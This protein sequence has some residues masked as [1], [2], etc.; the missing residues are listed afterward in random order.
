MKTPGFLVA[1]ACASPTLAVDRSK[2]R[3]CQ[4]TGFCR[5]NRTPRSP[6][7]PYR[8]LKESVANHGDDGMSAILTQAESDSPPLKFVAKFY[9]S[10]VAR[11]QIREANP[12]KPRWEAPDIVQDQLLQPSPY[13]LLADSDDSVMRLEFAPGHVLAI[14]YEPFGATLYVNGEAAVVVNGKNKFHFEYHRSRQGDPSLGSL[15]SGEEVDKHQGKKIVGY[16]EDGLAIY[17]DGSREE[18]ANGATEMD[19]LESEG[20]GFWEESFEGHRDSKPF[21]PASVGLDIS[22]P[23]SRHLY[24]LPE[25]ASSMV[26]KTTKGEGSH[27]KEPYRMYT[28]DVFEYELDEPMALYGGIPMVLS[29]TAAASSGAF[30]FN[31]SET[32]VDVEQ[33][34]DGSMETHWLSE[35]GVVDLMLLPGTKP[36]DILGQFTK[37]VGTQALPPMFALGY[38]Q[39]RWNYKDEKDVALV[40]AK[41]EELNFPY[42]VLWLDIEHTDGKR[43]FTWDKNLFPNPIAMQESLS[44]EGR[45]MVTIIDPH[46]KRDDS[47]Y[48]H[49]EATAKGL[50]VKNKDGGDYDGWCWPG[51]SSYLDFTAPHVRQWWA[52]Q[53]ALDKYQGST[54]DLFTWNDMNEPSVFNGPEVSMPKDARNLDGVEHR[55]WH[56]LYG[57]YQQKATAEGQIMRSGGKERPFVLSRAFYAGS[58]RYGAIWTGDN[59]AEW[60]HLKIAA[61]MLLSI[62]LGGLTFAGADVGGFFGNTESELMVR[63]MQAGS[64]TPF[65]RGHAHHDAKRREPWMFGEP[66]T[67]QIRNTVMARYALLPYWYTLFHE[68]AASGVPTMRPLFFEYPSDEATFGIDDQWMVGSDLLVKPVTD[69]GVVTT[70]LYLP[71]NEPWYDV[72][73]Y[74]SFVGPRILTM[75]TPLE[76]I[77]AL[78]RG[79]S[80]IPRKLRLRRSTKLMIDDPYTLFI[81]LDSK[82]SAVGKLY[83]DDEHTF[84]FEQGDFCLRKYAFESGVL[85]A[86]S[87][88]GAAMRF[89]PTNTI[90]RVVVIGL[91]EAP[92]TVTLEETGRSR[93]LSFT[94]DSNTHV[95]T[96]RKP[97]VR[98]A[99]DFQIILK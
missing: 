9:E 1:L 25:H 95:L 13:Q 67:T 64:F 50:Y 42:D 71:G 82:Q 8:L 75:S 77:A 99:G 78:Q 81:A 10:G 36:K 48:I 43:Y 41:F 52:E 74:E 14:T 83:M 65:F 15:Q 49:S 39:C 53:F 59:A 88:S 22:F 93:E 19:R 94:F 68:A 16:W 37:L 79:G 45:R 98:A 96:I 90:E 34:P 24:G 73:T 2:F 28:L 3:T 26:L 23:G 97:D 35:S 58:Q 29:H 31:P 47:Y 66:T 63:W 46:L 5:R 80:I 12:A 89:E 21:G 30:W 44:R 61:P 85:S 62:G 76:K 4:D 92:K 69:P 32:F 70:E 60:S 18:K 33:G 55:E 40:H 72:D 20:D 38:H 57:M 7:K 54:L 51:S 56:N 27:Y 17:E 6:P 91:S 86:T 84:D 11:L 87:A